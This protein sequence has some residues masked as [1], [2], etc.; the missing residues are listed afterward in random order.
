M[1]IATLTLIAAGAAA[2]GAAVS[3]VGSIRAG[4]D[5]AAASKYNALVEDQNAVAARQQAGAA[6]EQKDN[7]VTR[8]LADARAAFAASGV[9][10]NS[11]T[12]LDVMADSA[13]QGELSKR[14]LLYQGDLTARGLGSQ[15]NLDRITGKNAQT[16]GYISA[17]GTL[18][19]GA[20]KAAG[21]SYSSPSFPSSV[22]ITPKVSGDW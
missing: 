1:C 7:E 12:P 17:A 14:L 3:A 10:P 22:N 19:T 15:A 21:S 11:G 8:R 13:S 20:G 5:Q 18:L 4:N 16:A 2:A 9:D 6:A